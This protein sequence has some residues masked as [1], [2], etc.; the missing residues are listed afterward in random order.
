M[1]STCFT[2]FD[3]A[4]A[5]SALIS[6]AA[7]ELWNRARR[8]PGADHRREAWLANARFLRDIGLDPVASLGPAPTDTREPVPATS[9]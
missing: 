6:G 1:C 4:M 9:R 8:G 2:A 3:A 5:N 7:L